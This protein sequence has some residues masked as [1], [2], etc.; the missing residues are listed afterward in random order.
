M[1]YQ[2]VFPSILKKIDPVMKKCSKKGVR[3]FFERGITRFD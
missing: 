1:K 2:I 3:V